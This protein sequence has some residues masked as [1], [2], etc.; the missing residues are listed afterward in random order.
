MEL[1]WLFRSPGIAVRGQALAPP[2]CPVSGRGLSRGVRE[3]LRPRAVPGVG[4]TEGFG[5]LCPDGP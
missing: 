1:G 5:C 2:P 4:F 3:S